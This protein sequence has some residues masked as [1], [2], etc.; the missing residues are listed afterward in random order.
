MFDYKGRN[1][2]SYDPEGPGHTF[3][4]SGGLA[5]PGTRWEVLRNFASGDGWHGDFHDLVFF[6]FF[7]AKEPRF[8]RVR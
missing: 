6:H 5:A 8:E 2:T 3:L 7:G 4:A 1:T